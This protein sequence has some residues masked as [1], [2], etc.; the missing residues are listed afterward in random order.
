MDF[1][2]IYQEWLS[3]F[4]QF[5]P[6]ILAAIVIFIVTLIGSGYFAKWIKRISKKKITSEEMLQLISRIA[7]WTVLIL[8]TVVALGQVNFDVTGF[9]AGLGVAGFTIGFA[10]QD[11]A[12][13]FI[14]GL[15]LLYSQPFNLGDM[16]MVSD[17]KGEVKEINVR[18]TVIATLDGELV[19]IPNRDV[20]ENPIINYTHTR[21]RRRTIM[22]GL[23][24]EEDADRAIE[25]FLDTIKSVPGVE[26]DPAPSIRAEELGESALTISALFW[27]DQKNSD[28]LGVHSDVVKAIKKASEEHDINL[29]YP[30]QTVLLRNMRE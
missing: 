2:E 12:K 29:P 13:N 1:Q 3:S 11:I 21:L 18:D 27:V 17:Y 10:L 16:V 26:T 6:R 5:L 4:L 19:I 24:Y 14:S 23:G 30:V 8:G 25:I 7:R 22:I 9:I 15:L 28:L 20:F